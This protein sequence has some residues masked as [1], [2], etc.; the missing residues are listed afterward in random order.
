MVLIETTGLAD[1]APV[2]HTLMARPSCPSATGS[3]AW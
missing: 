3:T 2:I 1:P